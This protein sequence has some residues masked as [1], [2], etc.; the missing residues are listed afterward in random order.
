[1]YDIGICSGYFGILHEGHIEY[2]KDAKKLCKYLIV[3]L[4]NNNQYKNKYGNQPSI[5]RESLLRGIKYID[6]VYYSHDKDDSVAITLEHVRTLF[7]KHSIAFFNSG[8]RNKKTKN[9][10]ES[11]SCVDNKINE[12]FIECSKV[13]SSSKIMEQIG[14]H[15]WATA[16]GPC[17]YTMSVP[18]AD[19]DTQIIYQQYNPPKIREYTDQDGLK[20]SSEPTNEYLKVLGKTIRDTKI[21]EQI[22]DA[23]NLIKTANRV[24]IIGNGGS[25]CVAMHICED[26]SKC[27]GINAL[28][29]TNPGETTCLAN[30]Y[31]YDNIYMNWLKNNKITDEDVL[32]AISS[33]GNSN[34][35]KEALTCVN[36]NRLITFTAM[37]KDNKIASFHHHGL[38]FYIPTMSYG[39]AETISE[40]LLHMIV[41]KLSKEKKN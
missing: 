31:G 20:V 33:S 24:F 37:K 13:N 25:H 38:H 23:T 16:F 39:V 34:N 7:P 2:F 40:I 18:S 21:Q 4:N 41:D 1:M 11:Q 27:C 19:S 12:V 9:T 10:K 14:K 15:Y 3:I 26:L 22:D 8:D 32:I 30:D 36:N 29:L 6:E 28:C 17:T 35:I 5:N